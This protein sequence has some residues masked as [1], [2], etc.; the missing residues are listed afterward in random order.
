HAQ[1]SVR[2]AVGPRRPHNTAPCSGVCTD[3]G[4]VLDPPIRHDREEQP[5]GAEV[6]VADCS[7]PLPA[8]RS[9]RELVRSRADVPDGSHSGYTLEARK[10]LAGRYE[11]PRDRCAGPPALA[12]ACQNGSDRG[13]SFV[14][15][16]FH[17]N[18]GSWVSRPTCSTSS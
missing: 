4:P 5:S 16:P 11:P 2:G 14:W 1:P 18:S 17:P 15:S 7:L 6:K 3:S 10:Q 9:V 8:W 13:D 12:H